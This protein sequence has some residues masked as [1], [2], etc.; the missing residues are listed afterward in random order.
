MQ[1]IK[2][3]GRRNV[4]GL[5]RRFRR[6]RAG[7]F[8]IEMALLIAPV[9]FSSIFVMDVARFHIVGASLDDAVLKLTQEVRNGNV[10]TLNRAGFCSDYSMSF[11]DADKLSLRIEPLSASASPGALTP[12]EFLVNLP[13]GDGS[14]LIRV[15]YVVPPIVS[16]AWSPE[17]Y[18]ISA[19]AF[20]HAI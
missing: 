15:Q 9:I 4:A 1:L 6:E 11:C 18:V 16:F 13:S 17:D 7:V 12:G 5:L 19:G 20:T 8:S 3:S 10:G 2:P 14:A